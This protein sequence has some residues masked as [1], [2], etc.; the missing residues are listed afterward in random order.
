MKNRTDIIIKKADKGDTIVVETVDNYIKDGLTHLSNTKYYH[1]IE[2]DFNPN[3]ENAIKKFLNNAHQ[4]GLI[5]S[6]TF[7][8]LSPPSPSRTP[9]IYF[10]KK[11]HKQPISVRPIVSH[12]NSPTSNISSFI[13]NL[14]KPIVKEIPHILSNSSELIRDLLTIKC[15]SSSILA[16]LD[17]NSLYP[18]IPIEE[19]ISIILNIIKEYNNPT[20]PPICILNKL[21]SFVLHYNCFNFGD[22]FFLQIHGIAMGTKLAPNYANLFMSD[23][24]NKHVF[25]QSHQPTY[26]RRYIDDI[27]FIWNGLSTELDNFIDHLN[28]AHP[29]IKF[30]KTISNSQVTFLDLDIYK[31]DDIYH[32][33]PHFKPTNTFSYVH[34]T[35]NHPSSTFKGVTTG[36][37]IRILRNTSEEHNYIKTM[38]FIKERFRARKY[39]SHLTATPSIDFSERNN[40]L[41]SSR[42]KAINH[43]PTFITTFDPTIPLK[44]IICED[45]P[46]LTS[47]PELRNYFR[48]PPQ[49]TY[50]HSP[51]LAQLLV[52][53]KLHFTIS[54]TINSH[55]VPNIPVINYPAK[56]IKCRHQQCATCPQLTEKSHYNSFQTKQYYPINQI[57]SCDTT[58]A[59]YLLECQYCSKQYIGETHTTVRSRMKHHR[60]ISKTALNRPIYAHLLEHHGSFS[61]YSI[62]V[63]DRVQDTLQRKQ[64]EQYYINL[65]KTKIPFGLN[66]INKS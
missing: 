10:L 22:L 21:L 13:D 52:R 42:D 39:P 41:S 5:D 6:D 37:N 12:V 9:L 40:H 45:W 48:Q 64:K 18:N 61:I 58:C 35:S 7:K 55:P 31:K 1:R 44:D 63:I 19:S 26:Y 56:N 17:V 11:L 62:T 66:V 53:A 51:N 33:K 25:T 38:D 36:E 27:F 3:I 32:T 46:R 43:C 50:R 15:S 14:L 59:I 23:F 28:S 54:T 29:T 34:G 60:N 47:N 4:R 2:E 57:F 30:T 8:F 20:Y 49:I 65:L 16:T 24:E